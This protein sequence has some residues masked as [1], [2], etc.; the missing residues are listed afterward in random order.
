[1]NPASTH[2]PS[3]SPTPQAACRACQDALPDLLLDPGS[4]AA[5]A[6]ETHLQACAACQEE[7]RALQSTS[8]LLDSWAA[9]E[10][11]P[12]FDGRLHARLREVQ[13]AEPAGWLE[14]LQSRLL[15]SSGRQLRPLL[16]GGLALLLAIGGGTAAFT[17]YHDRTA[18]QASAAVEDLQ[19]LDRND[20]ALQTMDQLLDDSPDDPG[21]GTT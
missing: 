8:T 20:Q 16:A 13:A 6:A 9:P 17:V 7:L 4:S 1:M 18:A 21:Q 2:S 15:F 5:L 11:S 12:W 10:P 19:I 14:R 3:A